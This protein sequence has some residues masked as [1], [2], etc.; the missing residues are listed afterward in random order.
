MTIFLT[1]SYFITVFPSCYIVPKAKAIFFLVAQQFHY[2][3]VA[4]YHI[5]RVELGR[6]GVQAGS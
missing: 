1:I 5:L 4:K 3:P 6:D 2:G